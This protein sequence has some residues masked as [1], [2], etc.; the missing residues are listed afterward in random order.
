MILLTAL[1]S[2]W[3]FQAARA[4]DAPAQGAV[5]FDVH[6]YRVLG[7]SVLTNRQIEAVLYPRLGNDRSF[8]DVDAA[9]A[10]L[11]A[12]YHALGYATVFVDVP[13][14]QVTDGVVRLHVTEGRLRERTIQGARYFSERQILQQLPATAPGT[15]PRLPDVQS[16][17]GALNAQTTDR[18][19]V[20]VLKAGPAPGTVDL[21]LNVD[22]H[23]P[24]HGSLELNNQNTP[25]TEAL[26]ATAA[27][28]YDN[29]FADLDSIAAQYTVAPQRWGQ[30]GVFN[31]SY[32]AQPVAHG[33]RPSFSFTNSSS[34]VSTIG[35]LGV[36]GQGQVYSARLGDPLI[37][38]PGDQQSVTLGLDY[39]HFR[40]TIDVAATGLDIQPIS[41]VNVSV[42]YSGAW[43]QTGTSG[44]VLRYGSL[45]LAA[46]FGPRGLTNG[47]TDFASSRYLARSNYAYL[48]TDAAITARLP[49]DLQLTLR[50]AAQLALE[51][52]V[53]YEQQT[54]AG[55]DGVRGYLEAEVLGD[56]GVKGTVQLQS[57]P[58]TRHGSM[59]G[60]AFVFF[61][62]GSSHTIDALPGQPGATELRS[63]GAGMELLPGQRISGSLTWAD[64]LV[65]G[66]RT[67]AYDSRLLF[68][69][70]GSF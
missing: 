35:T 68:Q 48:R 55:A 24:L 63:A 1:G 2:A 12:A 16:E 44:G 26:R 13:P 3:G 17:L 50:A 31:A 11:E 39:K 49:L 34:N 33:L 7:N 30:V 5:H 67:R 45:N 60:D 64:P 9:R 22:D 37:R 41:Y 58:L 21:A 56:S 53:A 46:N 32:S 40:N 10:A 42:V 20:P 59:L 62:A 23:L 27:L 38:V 51:P 66:P 14:Q 25:D 15:V 18:A 52:L 69:L 28:S 54:I 6:E 19:V 43:Q 36:L 65:E 29:L 47:P 8:A 70:R 57:P 4:E 61:D